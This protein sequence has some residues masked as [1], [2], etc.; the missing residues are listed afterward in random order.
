MSADIGD[1][2][3]VLFTSLAATES[4]ETLVVTLSASETS[5]TETAVATTT[6]AA[7]DTTTAMTTDTATTTA[8]AT[9]TTVAATTSAAPAETCHGLP[10]EYTAPQ[11]TTFDI[12]CRRRPTGTVR[13]TGQEDASDF[14]T[15]VDICDRDQ[16]CLGV[17]WLQDSKVCLLVDSFDG[18]EASDTTDFAKA[19]SRGT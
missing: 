2:T 18:S 3:T 9:T 14:K 12:E 5:N 4:T 16:A 17:I 6:A 8:D 13:I 11:G 10:A 1:T 15:C 7:S 19:R